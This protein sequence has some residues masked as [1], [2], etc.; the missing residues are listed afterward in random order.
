MFWHS[1]F[2]FGDGHILLEGSWEFMQHKTAEKS[3]VEARRK[4]EWIIERKWQKKW[5]ASLSE[6]LK[7]MEMLEILQ[8]ILTRG[9]HH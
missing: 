3:T 4:R 5:T 1:E 9:F 7:R 8:V 6:S 2:C